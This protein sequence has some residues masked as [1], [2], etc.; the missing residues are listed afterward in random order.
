MS[1]TADLH[2]PTVDTSVG[3]TRLLGM[4]RRFFRESAYLLIGLPIAIAAFVVVVTGL[5]VGGGLLIT[6]IGLPIL[7]LTLLAARG[8]AEV[9]RVQMRSLLDMDVPKAR[10][11]RAEPGAGVFRRLIVPLIDPQAWLD[12]LHACISFVT[13]TVAWSFAVSWWAGALGGLT[14]PAWG[15]AIPEGRDNQDLPDLLGFGHLY[16]GRTIFYVA[17]GIFFA[18]T[19]PLVIFGFT[20][21]RAG[22]SRLLLVSHG[23]ARQQVEDLVVSRSAGRTAE[24]GALRRLER[25]I[26]DGPQQ[27]LVR[28]SMDLGRARK[29]AGDGNPQLQGTL[30]AALRQTQD[31]LEELRALSR[32]IAPPVLADRGLRAAL[33]ELA[34]RSIIPI[35]VQIDLP[36]R[37][38][39]DHVETAVYF[40]VSEA[41]ANVAKHS[42]A[43]EC[44]MTVSLVGQDVRV[45]V[46]DDGRGGA[47][48]SK[49][50]GLVGLADRVRAADGVLNVTSPDGGPTV[51]EAE[52][53][54]GS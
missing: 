54:C 3:S 6:V 19:L 42:G 53:P 52:V 24:A 28:L 35:H 23:E 20:F 7:T 17:T 15:W 26:H 49:G 2:T 8:F 40:V 51:V 50:H 29:Q 11:R 1:Y 14:Y 12:V 4:I 39:P 41:M 37:R 30:D 47:H 44:A 25:D 32:G 10:Y 36:A 21:I 43:T 33:E 46:S 45:R 31:T 13:T 27:R 16:M 34:A 18:L 9:E 22:V 38:L 48:L 5:S